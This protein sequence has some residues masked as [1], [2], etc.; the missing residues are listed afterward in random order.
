MGFDKYSQQGNV[1]KFKAKVKYHDEDKINHYIII[2]V[3]ISYINE[4][5]VN[6][7]DINCTNNTNC[8]DFYCTYECSLQV[9]N[10]NISKVKFNDKNYNNKYSLSSLCNITKDIS[11]QK[12]NDNKNRGLLDRTN[13]TFLEHANISLKSGRHFVIR[14]DLDSNFASNNIKLI[15]SKNN[16]RR[17]LSCEGYKDAKFPYNYFLDC[18]TSITSINADLQNTFA[19]LE[20]DKDKG[21]IINFDQIGNSTTIQTNDYIPKRKSSGISIAPAGFLFLSI[22]EYVVAMFLSLF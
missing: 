12:E 13:I 3:N 17:D 16:Y 4:K 10:I 5:E 2:P 1:F 18:D 22:A 19:Y 21:F 15:L 11:S 7:R 14:G 20:N 8:I 9:E 6:S